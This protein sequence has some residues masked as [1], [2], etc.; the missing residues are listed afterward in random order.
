MSPSSPTASTG[1]TGTLLER[2]SIRIS[3]RFR[4]PPPQTSQRSAGSGKCRA[5]SATQATVSA[6]SVA[7][8]SSVDKPATRSRNPWKS[9]RSSDFG[10][11]LSRCGCVG[12][13]REDVGIDPSRRG[14]LATLVTLPPGPR[15]DEIVDQRIAGPVSKAQR[16][17]RFR[18]RRRG[19]TQVTLP[20]PPRLRKATGR[21]ARSVARRRNGRTAPAARPRRRSRHPPCGS[22]RRRAPHVA[23]PASL[24]VPAWWVPRPFGSC[25][26]VCPW[27]PTTST[28]SKPRIASACACRTT[29]STAI[30]RVARPGSERRPQRARSAGHTVGT[31]S[32]RSRRS[33]R[34]RSPPP[35]HRRRPSR[36]PTSLRA[37]ACLF[38]FRPAPPPL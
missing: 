13:I 37:P 34:R 7:A 32:A 21:V 16:P 27:K 4:R 14:K 30:H 28:P 17:L 24:P 26:S 19:S 38:P 20:T 12:K 10:G 23:V 8:P 1:S 11:G 15:P 35:L 18:P 6:A 22:P 31:R 29:A 25:A 9:C 33:S 36:F 3:V 2:A 5:P